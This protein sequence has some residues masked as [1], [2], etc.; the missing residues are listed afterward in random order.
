MGEKRT[1]KITIAVSVFLFFVAQIYHIFNGKIGPPPVING[2]LLYHFLVKRKKWARI[3]FSIFGV[4]EC[5]IC[6]AS[7]SMAIY[8]EILL[9][10]SELVIPYVPYLWIADLVALVAYIVPFVV[11]KRMY[12]TGKQ[13]GR[14]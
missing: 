13:V 3:I 6:I 14:R 4:I 8:Y 7:V 2:L 11:V 9:H 5:L 12:K 10:G 1:L